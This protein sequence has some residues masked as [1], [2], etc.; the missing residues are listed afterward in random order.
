M[1][2]IVGPNN[3]GSYQGNYT[4][5]I[6]LVIFRLIKDKLQLITQEE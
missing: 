2:A 5:K 6:K 3:A 1:L 4:D